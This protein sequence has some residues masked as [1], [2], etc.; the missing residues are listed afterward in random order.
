[1]SGS[2]GSPKSNRRRLNLQD[3]IPPEIKKNI[4]QSLE[5][6]RDVKNLG[7][8]SVGFN[9]EAKRLQFRQLDLRRLLDH[10]NELGE[11]KTI[12]GLIAQLPKTAVKGDHPLSFYVREVK[13]SKRD[14]KEI[15]DEELITILNACDQLLVIDI[16]YPSINIDWPQV[17]R[18]EPKL[19]H[20]HLGGSSPYEPKFTFW[21]LL[22]TVFDTSLNIKSIVLKPQRFTDGQEHPKNVTASKTASTPSPCRKLEK[23]IVDDE[24]WTVPYLK[25]LTNKAPNLVYARLGLRYE[26][27]L[28]ELK[29]TLEA[30][31]RVWSKTLKEIWICYFHDEDDIPELVQ[32]QIFHIAFP[33]MEKLEKLELVGIQIDDKSLYNLHSLTS[34][35]LALID[36]QNI[37]TT[38][39]NPCCL[40]KLSRLNVDRPDSYRDT[41]AKRKNHDFKMD[42]WRKY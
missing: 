37:A 9:V 8:T 27:N 11:M 42:Q 40:E 5:T 32:R 18:K 17:L 4:L 39:S 26:K 19:Q 24:V 23:V 3:D 30:S 14:N 20:L 6:N 34:L 10:P 22:S 29:S 36:H 13:Y 41:I 1:M 16:A 33:S 12:G 35:S 2:I 28:T 38:L 7:E 25:Y 15:T 31:L 21:S